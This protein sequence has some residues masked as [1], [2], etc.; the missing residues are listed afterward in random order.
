LW[1]SVPK[2]PIGIMLSPVRKHQNKLPSS[3]CDPTAMG[4]RQ[5]LLSRISLMTWSA[6]RVRLVSLFVPPVRL[7]NFNFSPSRKRKSESL[8]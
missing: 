8:Y 4:M 7:A 1:Q 5:L 6:E 2:E 3:P